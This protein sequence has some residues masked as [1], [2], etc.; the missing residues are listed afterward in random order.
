MFYNDNFLKLVVKID[1]ILKA[2]LITLSFC[3]ALNMSLQAQTHE[4]PCATAPD[5]PEWLAGYLSNPNRPKARNA[6]EVVYLPVTVHSVGKSDGSGHYPMLRIFESL[7]RLNQDFEPYN[8]QFYLKGEINLIN[9][10]LYYDHSNFGDGARLMRTFGKPL[11]INTFITNTAP[12]NACGY[13]HQSEDAIVV[14]KNCMGG[15]GHTWTHEIGHWLSL[16]HTFY[17]WENKTYDPSAETPKYHS[18]NGR[19]TLFVEDAI[20]VNCRKAGDGFC[21]TPADYLSQGWSCNGSFQSVQVQKDPLGVDFRSDG[22]N[23]MCYSTDACQSKFSD[24]QNEAML[25]YISF[26][27]SHV[28]SNAIPTGPVSADPITF[29]TPG[30]GEQVHYQSIKLEWN[31]HPN[32]TH[33]LVNISKFSFFVTVDYEFLVEGNSINIGDLPVDKKWFWRVKPYNAYDACATFTEAGSFNTYDVTAV[34]ELSDNNH[35]EIYPTLVSRNNPVLHISF[36]FSE[37]L[38]VNV[39]MYSLTGGLLKKNVY[40]NP[41]RSFESI[42]LQDLSAGLYLLKISSKKGSLIKK[43]TLQ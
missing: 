11:T 22:S 29:V 12:N 14:I 38:P 25:A 33:Y 4:N 19:D 1:I 18:I 41:G 36:D 37:L 6:D 32:A 7:C 20:G 28:V 40:A 26:A 42:D 8:I 3:L 35:L 24:E 5:Y 34:D 10:D 43:I 16:P 17:G 30:S 31:H 13:W 15:G 21:D 39:E 27:K 2:Y 9:R 23:F